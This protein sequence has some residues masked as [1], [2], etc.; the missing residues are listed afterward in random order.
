MRHH[1]E[2]HDG[3]RNHEEGFGKKGRHQEGDDD[4]FACEDED[5]DLKELLHH[6]KKFVIGA[7]ALAL[8]LTTCCVGVCVRRRCRKTSAPETAVLG[9][10]VVLEAEG[11]VVVDAASPAEGEVAT[12]LDASAPG[13]MVVTGVLLPAAKS[14]SVPM[15]A[16]QGM[17]AYEQ[18]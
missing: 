15:P 13:T 12:K 17:E 6:K 5:C 14:S 3:T 4:F 9:G 2:T 11:T 10:A 7:A 16:P 1:E 8:L 18:V